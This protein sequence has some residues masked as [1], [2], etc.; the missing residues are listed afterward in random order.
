MQ[1]IQTFFLLFFLLGLLST[2]EKKIIKEKN[3]NIGIK[4]I[5][6]RANVSIG[7]VDKVLH[8]RGGVSEKTRLRILKAIK[9]L[10]YKPNILASRL[11][12][13][14]EYNLAIL[15]PQGTQQIPFWFEH[16]KGFER[17]RKELDQFGINLETFHFDQNSASSFTTKLNKVIKGKYDGIFMVP[18]FYN[19]TIRLLR[20]AGKTGTPVIFFD[21]NIT[22]QGNLSFIG[23]NSRD[24][25][26]LAANLLDYGVSPE[27]TLLVATIVR[28]DDNHIHF[29]AR[30]AG[31]LAYFQEANRKI[32]HYENKSGNDRAIE[33]EI[34]ALLQREPGIEGIFVTNGISKIAATVSQL[35]TNRYKLVGYDLTDENI[36]FLEK[37]IIHFLINQQPDKQAYQGIK[38]FYE[39]LILKQ[40]IAKSYYMPIDIVTRCNLK[41]YQ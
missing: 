23:Q 13:K 40:P 29:S 32:I 12:S 7:P 11:K 25:G 37:G 21:S 15:L 6:E 19:E 8:N 16:Q 20:H 9:E 14:K 31:F 17:I 3:R 28:K 39:Y 2:F 10:D 36:F 27:A 24:S 41:Y 1:H 18:V 26:Y 33:K 22:D 4:E 5:A 34:T 38:L 30:E 35:N